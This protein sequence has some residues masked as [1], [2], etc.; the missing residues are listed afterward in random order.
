LA[1]P[2]SAAMPRNRSWPNAAHS[3]FFGDGE[4]LP[5]METPAV[6]GK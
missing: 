6:N 5:S 3:L 4:H 1:V 2:T